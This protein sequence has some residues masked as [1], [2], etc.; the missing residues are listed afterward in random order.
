LCAAIEGY[1]ASHDRLCL[2]PNARNSRHTYII[3]DHPASNWRVQQ[4]LVDPADLNDWVAE[5]H[6]NLDTSRRTGEPALG[7]LRLGPLDATREPSPPD[8]P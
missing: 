1:L 3:R 5:F 8:R 7:L 2:D 6:V 4:M